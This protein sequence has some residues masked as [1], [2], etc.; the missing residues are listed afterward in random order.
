MIIIQNLTMLIIKC[1]DEQMTSTLHDLKYM[2]W[3]KFILGFMVIELVSILFV[4]KFQIMFMNT[5]QKRKKIETVLKILNH[6]I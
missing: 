5:W 6:N 4:I 3:F 1:T 2:L